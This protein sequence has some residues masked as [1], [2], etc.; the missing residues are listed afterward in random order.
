M[1]TCSI[2]VP[3]HN[4]ADHIQGLFMDFWKGVDAIRGKILEVHLVENGS[5][6]ATYRV[7]KELEAAAAGVVKAHHLGK[8]SYGDAVKRGILNARGDVTVILECDAL[9][10]PFMSRSMALIEAGQADFVVG[11]KRHPESIDQRPLK[12]RMLTLFFNIALKLFFR[13]PGTDTHGLK[14]IRSPVAKELCG[15]SITG[16]E[17]FQTEIILLAHRLGYRVREVPVTIRE[18]RKTKILPMQRLPKIIKI[19]K[20]IRLSLRRFPRLPA[21]NQIN[22]AG[23][24]KSE[25]RL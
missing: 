13:F 3:V 14:A 15:K 24:S 12:R 7:C 22:R 11:S 8:A 9:D 4:E 17:V 18:Q 25:N 2:V 19:V 10:V 5:E 20:E 6:D 1:S 21:E 16:G 23:S